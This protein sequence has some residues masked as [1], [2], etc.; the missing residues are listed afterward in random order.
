MKYS[1]LTFSH[2]IVWFSFL[3]QFLLFSNYK[4]SMIGFHQLLHLL[5]SSLCGLCCVIFPTHT[6]HCSFPYVVSFTCENFLWF[7]DLNLHGEEMQFHKCTQFFMLLPLMQTWGWS[8][9]NVLKSTEICCADQI[10]LHDE[11][12]DSITCGNWSYE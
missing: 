7:Y 8:A 10:S 1:S 6:S 12:L 5:S 2:L 11:H 3:Q 4:L 9:S